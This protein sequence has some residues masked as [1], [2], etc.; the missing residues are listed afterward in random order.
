[1]KI[2]ETGAAAHATAPILSTLF[3]APAPAPMSARRRLFDEQNNA[4]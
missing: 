4:P 3:R 1:V 2:L